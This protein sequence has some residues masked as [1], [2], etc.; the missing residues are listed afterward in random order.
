MGSILHRDHSCPKTP[1]PAQ[2]VA[3]QTHLLGKAERLDTN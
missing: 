2:Q 1:K 3:P